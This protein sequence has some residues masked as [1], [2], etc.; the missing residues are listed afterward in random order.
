ML[1]V[2]LTPR[3]FL[4]FT[5]SLGEHLQ[6]SSVIAVDRPPRHRCNQRPPRKGAGGNR[7]ERH[8]SSLDVDFPIHHRDLLA[9]PY[10][11]GMGKNHEEPPWGP[12]VVLHSGLHVGA[13]YRCWSDRDVDRVLEFQ[14][15]FCGGDCRHQS[16]VSRRSQGST[17]CHAHRA[18][19]R[20]GDGAEPGRVRVTR[21]GFGQIPKPSVPS[22]PNC[23]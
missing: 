3:E 4:Q 8:H 2:E 6:V 5:Y 11:P 1:H 10:L 13:E 21:P 16:M 12:T 19:S 20:L 17:R 9:C 23:I 15:S 7:S 18:E 22:F 14:N